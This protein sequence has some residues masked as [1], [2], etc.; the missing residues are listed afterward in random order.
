[1]VRFNDTSEIDLGTRGATF[2]AIAIDTTPDSG[3]TNFA[4]NTGGDAGTQV[5]DTVAWERQ[6]VVN[7]AGCYADGS[8]PSGDELVA[9]L[10]ND[11]GTFFY[12]VNNSWRFITDTNALLAV[13][14]TEDII[15]IRV[16][17]SSLGI[18][19]DGN[20]FQLNISVMSSLGWSN[21]I[22][23]G[24]TWDNDIDSD[25]IDVVTGLTSTISEIYD[26]VI[27]YWLPV[28][29]D[30]TNG[31]VKHGSK[32]LMEVSVWPT[33]IETGETYDLWV[34]L[35][36][37][38]GLP[39]TGAPVTIKE[40]GADFYSG[41]TDPW[42]YLALH[43]LTKDTAGAYTYTAVT[44]AYDGYPANTTESASA[45]LKVLATTAT[46]LLL[47]VNASTA[48]LGDP[49]MI[50][51]RLE[52]N[53][54]GAWL[55]IADEN[56]SIYMNEVL[57]ANATTDANGYFELNTTAPTYIG[58]NIIRASYPGNPTARYPAVENTT[59]FDT[60]GIRSIDG[61]SVDWAGSLPPRDNMWNV[62]GNELVWKDALEDTRTDA[63][64]TYPSASTVSDIEEF[65]VTIDQYYIYFMLKLRDIQ[66][67]GVAGA[68]IIDIAVDRD[69]SSGSGTGP[70]P[71]YSDTKA[72]S[73]A[74][75]EAAVRVDLSV[76]ATC[77]YHGTSQ[78]AWSDPLYVLYGGWYLQDSTH[79]WLSVDNTTDVVEIAVPWDI[80]GGISPGD[81][82]RF[83]V[84]T[85]VGDGS[86]NF[87]D[88]SGS[89]ALDAITG[90][91]P[92]TWNEV[93]DGAVD[94]SL[95]AYV[96][97]SYVLEPGNYV[98]MYWV[99]PTPAN[100]STVPAG[101]SITFKVYGRD[102]LYNKLS[103]FVYTVFNATD[104]TK[105]TDIEANGLGEAEFTL[106]FSPGEHH[107]KVVFNGTGQV[108][109]GE[110]HELVL[111]A[112]P[113][114]PTRLNM[115]WSLLTDA[116][117]NGYITP[118]DAVR[119]TMTLEYY[120]KT[121]GAWKQFPNAEIRLNSTEAGIDATVTTD[122]SGVATYDWIVSDIGEPNWVRFDANY[123]GNDTAV[124]T[125][126]FYG[127]TNHTY[128]PYY[129]ARIADGD[130]SD[131]TRTPPATA[132]GITTSGMEIIITDPSGDVRTD[133]LIQYDWPKPAD[134]DIV[135]VRLLIDKYELYG[136]VK[137]VGDNSPHKILFIVVDV[138]P[139]NDTGT[140]WLPGY[141]DTMLGT[142]VGSE[143]KPLS[144]DYV[145]WINPGE[146]YVDAYNS[147][148]HYFYNVGGLAI[149]DNARIIE[150]YARLS[151]FGL[152]GT[153]L[154]GKQVRI[155]VIQ[156][157]SDYG[158]IFDPT[159]EGISSVGSDVYDVAGVSGTVGVEIWDNDGSAINDVWPAQDHWIETGFGI[160]IGADYKP[161]LLP[162]ATPTSASVV[163]S[164]VRLAIGELGNVTVVVSPVA[165]GSVVELKDHDTGDLLWTGITSFD[166]VAK[167][168]VRYNVKGL[169]TIDVYVDGALMTSF[170]VNVTGFMSKL[171]IDTIALTDTDNDGL[172]DQITVEGYLYWYNGTDWLPATG[173]TIN[174]ELVF[175]Y[176]DLKESVITN[177]TIVRND[178]THIVDLGVATVSTDG[179]F[180]LTTTL[181]LP[182]G[183]PEGG[184]IVRV[185][186]DGDEQR[187]PAT[188]TS[189]EAENARSFIPLYGVL[190]ADPFTLTGATPG[191]HIGGGQLLYVDPA[192][193]YV[194]DYLTG[195][196][197]VDLEKLWIGVSN[198]Y[199]VVKAD[200]AGD[201]TSVLGSSGNSAPFLVIMLDTTPSDTTDGVDSFLW[202]IP[203]YGFKHTPE[204]TWPYPPYSNRVAGKLVAGLGTGETKYTH[205]IMIS[206]V[207]P[208]N[209]AT[210][211]IV[212]LVYAEG[213]TIVGKPL[214]IIKMSEPV[215]GKF[216]AYIPLT[217]LG[218][219]GVQ[220]I[221]LW[222]VS[223]AI[224]TGGTIH[225]REIIDPSNQDPVTNGKYWH[226]MVYDVPGTSFVPDTGNENIYAAVYNWSLL[227]TI[228]PTGGFTKLY[229]RLEQVEVPPGLT[230]GRLYVGPAANHTFTYKLYGSEADLPIIGITVTLSYN[231]TTYTDTTVADGEVTYSF[232]V[233]S[234]DVGKN[235]VITL[236]SHSPVELVEPLSYNAR[237]L[238]YI[239]I[240][241]ATM[242]WI[243]VDNDGFVSRNDVLKFYVETKVFD[244]T[245]N[246]APVQGINITFWVHSTPYLLGWNTTNSS[247]IAIFTYTVTGDENIVGTHDIVVQAGDDTTYAKTQTIPPG[248][249]ELNIFMQPLPEIPTLPIILLTTLLLLI[250]I[251]KRK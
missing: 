228:D 72:G 88:I 236:T 5:S 171:L 74:Y 117:G 67:I 164:P 144:W 15:E 192:G 44:L 28:M 53:E 214:G 191:L 3:E 27:G 98:S 14:L 24:G 97:S 99:G 21:A 151:D 202:V 150:F 48:S 241:N 138:E 246:W 79:V 52:Q 173:N 118:G 195:A 87:H 242:T 78:P 205:A 66:K 152:D 177:T 185:T 201:L 109:S 190:P 83:T 231:T 30:G 229:G 248:A 198:G 23:S 102:S 194:T 220:D 216:V 129:I 40:N 37:E 146:G 9:G 155:W 119:I 12:M 237:V 17:W 183:Y 217:A 247:G 122:G 233:Y 154:A 238:Y 76:L 62:S 4:G 136:A 170:T 123:S 178:D 249:Q 95:T 219:N 209:P 86:G 56:V 31:E 167:L 54:T 251:K 50:Y 133:C 193:D 199:L 179:S 47:Y 20:D 168:G 239:R 175:A 61:N 149:S 124:G 166:G 89:N 244:E 90:Y 162:V 114:Y 127:S 111:F 16:S 225:A 250:I 227:L 174:I 113:I 142:I 163:V 116:D 65:R 75:W 148:Y 221:R 134:L 161:S 184:Y 77:T 203:G 230:D 106:T 29:F 121:E 103:H 180:T 125:P 158:D 101:V 208:N 7:L 213:S 60:A 110:T 33:T 80:I 234:S 120:N 172:P 226:T 92:N 156:F 105:I 115:M 153:E 169:H 64:A 70:L 32:V 13:N 218:I 85:G 139:L 34:R 126:R 100:G 186:Y 224:C 18:T 187:I 93:V 211:Y 94:Y 112:E 71:G 39:I 107:I 147:T 160:A 46:K 235:V 22:D 69:Q 243:D 206:P 132:P 137:Y 182:A 26:G 130:L 6:I 141:S 232:P 204:Y 11:W 140:L 55:P 104:N 96:A 159:D 84:I 207:E 165:T 42:G 135:E 19:L 58:T 212:W 157:A 68:P 108:P 189:L 10:Q 82:L 41:S 145:L 91:E 131:W 197:V 200:Y 1:M 222:A 57:I 35:Y 59:T 25:A 45:T 215:D 43:G 51:G 73:Y 143:L 240:I 36:D 176:Y 49:I 188:N 245:G 196:V 8:Y 181:S 2:L 210:N 38:L 63:D 223:G 128:I 81:R